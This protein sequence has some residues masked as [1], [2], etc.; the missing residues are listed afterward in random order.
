MR[1][2]IES[3][4]KI[5]D[6]LRKQ[7]ELHHI[8]NGNAE[9]LFEMAQKLNLTKEELEQ[10]KQKLMNSK[11]EQNSSRSNVSNL[12]NSLSSKLTEVYS[13][14]DHSQNLPTKNIKV[15]I[16]TLEKELENLQIKYQ[17]LKV[18]FIFYYSSYFYYFHNLKD[19]YNNSERRARYLAIK[20]NQYTPYLN[21]LGLVK[22]NNL[23]RCFSDPNL[24]NSQ[25]KQNVS[26]HQLEK[27]VRHMLNENLGNNSEIPK[28]ENEKTKT[29]D[30]TN[31]LK[32]LSLK[33][34]LDQQDATI[35]QYYEALS[36]IFNGF[37]VNLKLIFTVH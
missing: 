22:V 25:D 6:Y 23:K 35:K 5:N 1:K 8:T 34:K 7:L 32:N 13:N 33:I 26:D 30:V 11:K 17:K 20:F 9:S 28:T 36:N 12:A 21:D 27:L 15:S 3:A 16:I 24:K 14:H 37:R 19:L 18:F 4:E 31:E 29:Y 10:Y 2:K